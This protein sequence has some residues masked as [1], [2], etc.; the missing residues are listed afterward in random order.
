[1]FDAGGGLVATLVDAELEAGRH[2]AT[3]R[4]RDLSGHP[5]S[6]GV[7]FYRLSGPGFVC[8]NKMVLLK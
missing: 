4:G 2:D 1:V 6:S 7:Y 8:S 3:W 5:V